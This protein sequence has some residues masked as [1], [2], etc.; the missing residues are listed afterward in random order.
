MFRGRS[1]LLEVA[2]E[3]SQT[4]PLKLV[5]RTDASAGRKRPRQQIDLSIVG[6]DDEDISRTDRANLSIPVPEA[7]ADERLIGIAKGAGLLLARLAVALMDDWCKAQTGA[8]QRR[9]DL[10]MTRRRSPAVDPEHRSM[11]V[12]LPL[13]TRPAVFSG[14][15]ADRGSGGRCRNPYRSRRAGRP[16]FPWQAAPR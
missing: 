14:P 9:R 6:L 12:G 16:I 4:L 11:A 10:L 2:I 13:L 15:C 8:R 5:D 7:P 1:S 3:T